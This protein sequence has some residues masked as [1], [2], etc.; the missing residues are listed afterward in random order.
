VH[1]SRPEF[2]LFCCATL[3]LEFQESYHNLFQSNTLKDRK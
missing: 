3:I 2:D 1:S